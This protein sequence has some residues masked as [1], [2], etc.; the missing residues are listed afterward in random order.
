MADV[1]TVAAST[2]APPYSP[3]VSSANS[4]RAYNQLS[5]LRIGRIGTRVGDELTWPFLSRQRHHMVGVTL[6]TT[7]RVCEPTYLST[8][9]LCE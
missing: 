5:S 4:L 3:S 7:S 8:L 1:F 6:W 2:S 9:S